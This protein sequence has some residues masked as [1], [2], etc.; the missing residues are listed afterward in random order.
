MG[1]NS[2]FR[3]R[4]TDHT[5]RLAE[6]ICGHCRA[7]VSFVAPPENHQFSFT[8]NLDEDGREVLY[9]RF[10]VGF[11]P[12]P[13]C[14]KP[15]I[16]YRIIADS[17]D[18]SSED[19]VI[20]SEIVYPQHGTDRASPPEEVPEDLRGVFEEAA[21][22]EFLSPNGAAFL[23][24]RI[25]EQVL[26]ERS[27]SKKPLAQLIDNFLATEHPPESLH[28]LMHDVREFGNIAGHP[29]RSD[30]GDW[31]D[32]EPGE[33][34]YILDVVGELLDFVY[35]RPKRQ[36]EMRERWKQKKS[37]KLVQPIGGSKLVI[38]PVNP[39]EAEPSDQWVA[40]PFEDDDDLPF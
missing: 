33:A 10:F 25:L 37:G 20:Q 31:I 5:Y 21:R 23:A 17:R 16:V 38:Q 8:E 2:D 11:C 14:G 36:E 3:L 27:G 29:S 24:R 19:N 35:V 34:T 22:I 30:Q 6:G 13:S 40:P 12:R 7:F 4:W 15:T 9:H 28:G 18:D 39:P 26:R 1:L 32:V